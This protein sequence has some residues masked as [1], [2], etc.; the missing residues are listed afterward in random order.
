VQVVTGQIL[1]HLLQARQLFVQVAA[2]V[3][4]RLPVARQEQAVQVQA[5]ALQVETQQQ[6]QAQA[7]AAV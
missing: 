6:T 1:Q 4:V 5:V 2:V 7:A 3:G